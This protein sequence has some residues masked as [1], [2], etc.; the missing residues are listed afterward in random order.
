MKKGSFTGAH[1][2]KRGKFDQAN[3]GILFL[4][5]IG[6][7]SLKTQAKILRILQEQKFE[8]VGGN[9]TITVNVRVLAA[10]NKNLEEEIENGNFRADL[11]WRLNVVPINVP[12]LRDRLEDIPLLVEDLMDGLIEKG[13]KRKTFSEEALK[14]MM[15]HSWPG[16]VRELRNFVERIAIMCPQEIIAT[17]HI[18]TFLAQTA[19]NPPLSDKHTLAPY[20]TDDFKEAR[21]RFEREYLHLKLT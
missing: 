20:Q 21:K 6:D 9:K 2:N 16:N 15:N 7:M 8:R 4:D 10:T 18:T 14:E 12:H 11:F 13:L 3:G 5:E 19:S 17:Q 1:A